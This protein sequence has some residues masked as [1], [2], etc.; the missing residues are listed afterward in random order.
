MKYLIIDSLARS[1]T[2][3]LSSI[4]RTQ[5]GCVSFD[6]LVLESL[7]YASEGWEWP[8]GFAMQPLMSLDESPRLSPSEWRERLRVRVR[9][10]FPRLSMGLSITEWDSLLNEIDSFENLEIFYDKLAKKFDASLIAF[11]WNQHLFYANKWLSKSVDHYWITAIRDPRDRAVSNC[12][13][14]GWDIGKNIQATDSYFQKYYS[15]FDHP[16][17]ITV[18]Y[19]DIVNNTRD[20][21]SDLFCSID[22]DISNLN[23]DSL[24]GSD[25][26][27]YKNQG[28]R[29][30]TTFKSHASGEQ[31]NGMYNTSTGQY[32]TALS[33]NDIRDFNILIE[34]YPVLYRYR[35]GQSSA[36][37]LQGPVCEK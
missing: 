8:L 34:K 27:P 30:K 17:F 12:R 35:D 7:A 4:I 18:Y 1:G 11:R 10:T 28:W 3:L 5:G 32:K 2:T 29:V 23:L 22:F 25:N 36:S 16:R 33:P 13:T 21:V 31:Y 14:H 9:E 20:T 19:E 6:G 26:T 37:S 24:V 15:V